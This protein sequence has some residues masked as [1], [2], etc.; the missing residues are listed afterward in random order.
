MLTLTYGHSALPYIAPVAAPAFTMER[1][2]GL[3]SN[4]ELVERDGDMMLVLF[5]DTIVFV[6]PEG[7]D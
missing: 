7:D 6:A 1:G 2:N 4:F 5:E 3:K